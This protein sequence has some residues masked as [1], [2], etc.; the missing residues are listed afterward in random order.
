MIILLMK[1]LYF[2]IISKKFSTFFNFRGQMPPPKIRRLFS[3]ATIFVG[4]N[5]LAFFPTIVIT[6]F[7]VAVTKLR[8][9]T[10]SRYQL[11]HH[12]KNVLTTG[13]M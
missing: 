6:N 12:K 10:V 5:V 8:P 11:I 1:L 13:L 3:A 7:V 9:L 4:Q 2:C